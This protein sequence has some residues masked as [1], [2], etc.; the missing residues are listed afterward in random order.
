M[1]DLSSNDET[2]TALAKHVERNFPK[3]EIE[4]FTWNAGP[5]QEKNPH[6]Q[7]LR[8]EPDNS[9]GT[10]TYISIGAWA[11]T[12]SKDHGVEFI[13]S[14]AVQDP[15][16]IELLAAA[17]YYHQDH[18]LGLGRTL[19]IGEPWLPGSKCNQLLIS[20]PYPWGPELQTCHVGDRHVDFLW[21]L[22]ITEEESEFKA[23]NGL[24]ALESL[25]DDHG[26]RYW[27]PHRRSVILP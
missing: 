8:I 17:A 6:F 27:D 13:I 7:V 4:V 9:S 23:E 15:R 2:C 16:A 14:M 11:A 20:L 25:F 10:W 18:E 26:L 5:I 3:R 19:P 24:E 12:S 1:L 22:P 21:L